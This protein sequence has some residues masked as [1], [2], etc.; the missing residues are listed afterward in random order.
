[1]IYLRSLQAK[2]SVKC[3]VVYLGHAFFGFA[4]QM[5][6]TLN[7]RNKTV[8]ELMNKCAISARLGL[9]LQDIYYGK[10]PFVGALALSVISLRKRPRRS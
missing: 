3:T 9:V 1:M 5:V 7:L 4:L 6:G 2:T 10:I 8:L